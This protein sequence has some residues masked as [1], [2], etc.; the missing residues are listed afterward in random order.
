MPNS[1]SST[2]FVELEEH[3]KQNFLTLLLAAREGRLALVSA[4]DTKTGDSVKL[5]CGINYVPNDPAGNVYHF[6]PLATLLSVEDN[7]SNS[8]DAAMQNPYERYVIPADRD[9]L[10][11]QEALIVLGV[12][13]SDDVEEN[14]DGVQRESNSE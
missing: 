10:E 11:R 3:E 6:V 12:V 8:G 14:S 7:G 9:I 13:S 4:R 2:D 5:M 1:P